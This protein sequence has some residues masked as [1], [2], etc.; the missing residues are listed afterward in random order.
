MEVQLLAT[1]VGCLLK[2]L[3][4]MQKMVE[5]YKQKIANCSSLINHY[6]AGNL[7]NRAGGAVFLSRSGMICLL[8]CTFSKNAANGT[9]GG[10]HV[11]SSTI[12]LG[13]M[14]PTFALIS[15]SRNVMLSFTGNS[16]QTEGG[17]AYLQSNSKLFMH[18]MSKTKFTKN[19]ADYGG[20]LYVADD[21]YLDTCSA[22]D[23]CFFREVF[24]DS[25]PSTF[26]NQHSFSILSLP[27]ILSKHSTSWICTFWRTSRSLYCE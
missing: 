23:D 21:T 7:A 9:G 2:W 15:P 19:S 27:R 18:L 16:A 22:T 1:I 5:P 11:S 26:F 10:I 20:A 13:A 12:T 17:G 8:N 6:F 14:E 24:T 4:I 3:E 25:L